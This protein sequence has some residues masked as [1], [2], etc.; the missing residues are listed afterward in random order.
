TMVFDLADRAPI[1]IAAIVSA[2]LQESGSG[3][4]A[5]PVDGLQAAYDEFSNTGAAYGRIAG[6]DAKGYSSPQAAAAETTAAASG[7]LFFMTAGVISASTLAIGVL[8]A[9]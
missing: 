9:L 6:P 2:P 7:V 1:E 4:A 8:T 5:R 3:L